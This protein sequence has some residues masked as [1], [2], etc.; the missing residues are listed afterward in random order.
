MAPSDEWK[1]DLQKAVT[2]LSGYVAARETQIADL[3]ER[4]AGKVDERTEHRH[5]ETID[6]VRAGLHTGLAKLVE[7][8]PDEEDPS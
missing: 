3:I 8:Q 4:T 2:S 1:Q 6:K 5:S 7:H